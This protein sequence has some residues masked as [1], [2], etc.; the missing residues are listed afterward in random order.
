MIANP[1]TDLPPTPHP[2]P[3]AKRAMTDCDCLILGGGAV[4]LACASVLA[5]R[6]IDVQ[7]VD[8]RPAAGGVMQS[9]RV[10]GYLLERG[11][12]S[13]LNTS[14]RVERWLAELGTTA[15]RCF[16]PAAAARRYILRAGGLCALP[17]SA[18][19][20][21]RTPA[22]SFR[23][24]LRLMA[25]PL[26]PRRRATTEECL[27]DFVR[28]RLGQEGLDYALDPFVS[29]VYAGDPARIAIDAAFP[30]MVGFERDHG[31]LVIGMIR[32]ARARRADPDRPA[33]RALYAFQEGMQQPMHV[34]AA[35]L[36]ERLHLGQR[37]ER[38]V[39]EGARLRVEGEGFTLTARRVVCATPAY[40]AAE[41]LAPL[42]AEAARWLREIEHNP[43]AQVYL[44]YRRA[45]V[46]HPLDGFG[47]LFPS[48]E[49]KLTLGSLWSSTLF[50]GRAPAGHCLLTNFAGGARH[51]EIRDLAPATIQERVVEE[52]T[53]LLDLRGAPAFAQVQVLPRAIPHYTLGHTARI[54]AIERALS[55]YPTLHL[56]GNYLLGISVSDC[57]KRGLLLGDR[58]AG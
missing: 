10:D 31:S 3:R 42:S 39:A 14:L 9:E 27:A 50:P 44:G 8:P 6:G 5:A 51:P 38:V 52:L 4:G 55:A 21:L 33:N 12:N 13:T 53:P 7:V 40:V 18:A 17:T 43:V 46:G 57:W 23:G 56:T 11:P 26:I 25:E 41:L 37:A 29:G 32:T 1:P 45:Q 22:W 28:R 19:A 49:G 20:F 30:M 47:A 58:L 24:K 54:Q 35:R 2:P 36:G 16:G 15:A 34:A 48:K